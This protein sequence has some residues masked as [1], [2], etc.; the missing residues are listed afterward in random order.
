MEVPGIEP[1]FQSGP[2]WGF[3]G[4]ADLSP[5]VRLRRLAWAHPPL[6]MDGADPSWVE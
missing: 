5:P 3:P 4:W 2:S 1:G 6:H